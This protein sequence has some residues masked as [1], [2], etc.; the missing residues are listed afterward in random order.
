V[1]YLN[2]LSRLIDEPWVV[3]GCMFFALAILET[4]RRWVRARRRR[5]FRYSPLSH[6]LDSFVAILGLILLAVATRALLVVSAD[7][8]IA[9]ATPIAWAI[10]LLLILLIGFNMIRRLSPTATQQKQ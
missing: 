4:E 8:L 9:A 2:A 7:R 10:G 5:G 3:P 1:E 6:L